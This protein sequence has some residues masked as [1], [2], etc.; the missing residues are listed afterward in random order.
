MWSVSASFLAAALLYIKCYSFKKE[1]TAIP[2][3]GCTTACQRLRLIR[4]ISEEL[5][6]QLARVLQVE[7]LVRLRRV[8]QAGRLAHA[9]EQLLP[10][11]QVRPPLARKALVWIDPSLYLL[12]EA[13]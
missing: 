13:A 11:A 4:L 3:H 10:V 7:V 1:R 9:E 8:R 12:E 2:T 5:Q 6:L